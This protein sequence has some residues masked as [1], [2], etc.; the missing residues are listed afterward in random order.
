[1]ADKIE[2]GMSDKG[3]LRDASKMG[4]NSQPGMY[5][6]IALILLAL[7]AFWAYSASRTPTVPTPQAATTPQ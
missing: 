2:Q 7:V 4:G 6:A 1:M 3:T 5:V